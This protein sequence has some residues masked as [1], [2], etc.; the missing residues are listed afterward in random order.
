MSEV[1]APNSVDYFGEMHRGERVLTDSDQEEVAM[2]VAGKFVSPHDK[3]W[4]V[5]ESYGDMIAKRLKQSRL[6]QDEKLSL[7]SITDKMWVQIYDVLVSGFDN[8]VV[9]WSGRRVLEEGYSDS[10][11]VQNVTIELLVLG[12]RNRKDSWNPKNDV[13]GQVEEYTSKPYWVE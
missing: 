3:K 13:I 8:W 1:F 12:T 9:L 7:T 2:R 4:T 11:T 6:A 10:A 5:I